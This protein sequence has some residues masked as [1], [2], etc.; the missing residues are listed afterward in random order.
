MAVDLTKS[1]YWMKKLR[2]ECEIRDANK[3]G[4]ISKDDFDLIT[5]RYKDMGMSDERIKKLS[6]H[7]ADFMVVLGIAD[8]G[9]KL[10][11]EDVIANFSK[12][13]FDVLGKTIDAHFE[14]I[15]SNEDGEISFNEWVDAYKA[16]DIDVVHARASFDAMDANGDGMISKEEFFAYTKEYYTSTEDKLKSSIMYGPLD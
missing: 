13:N 16:M 10:R 2:R 15:D 3:D 9:V 14:I 7:Y 5:V 11:Y 4:F 12:S 8:P 6:C 1:D